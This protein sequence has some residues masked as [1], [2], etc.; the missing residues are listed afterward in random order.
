MGIAL[1]SVHRLEKLLID[2]SP[3]ILTAAGVLGV[4][5]TAISTHKAAVKARTILLEADAELV[6]EAV[7]RGDGKE[8]EVLSNKQIAK[9]VWVE[10]I[11]PVAI[12]AATITAIVMANRIGNRRAAALAI[13]AGLSEKRLSEYKDKV[14]ETF[15]DKEAKKVSDSIAQDKVDENPPAKHNTVVIVGK[16]DVLCHDTFSGQYFRSSMDTLKKAEND[17][18]YQIIHQQY[19][20]LTDFYR[21]L[22]LPP[23]DL[24]D[25]LGW[26]FDE[27]VKLEIAPTM[28]RDEEPCLAITFHYYPV[29]DYRKLH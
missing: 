12:G 25:E 7:M 11:P 26:S 2:N 4:V 9:L 1:P 28:S 16:G 14:V 21:R 13:A 23:T 29:H 3:L 17:T 5:G 20:T 19:A 27:L 8:A 24:S 10:Y 6:R 18:N 22:G 15:G